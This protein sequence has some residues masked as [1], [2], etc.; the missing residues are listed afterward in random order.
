MLAT[1]GSERNAK[2][3]IPLGDDNEFAMNEVRIGDSRTEGRRRQGGE[4]AGICEESEDSAGTE[5]VV[6]MLRS[7]EKDDGRASERGMRGSGFEI[8]GMGGTGPAIVF[9]R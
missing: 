4:R 6:L 1:I 3:L 5:V 9:R 8:M 7:L 2:G